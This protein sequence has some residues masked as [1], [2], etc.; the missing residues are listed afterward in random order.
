MTSAH[1]CGELKERPRPPWGRS[2]LH[3]SFDLLFFGPCLANSE[4]SRAGTVGRYPGSQH[5]AQQLDVVN[6][7]IRDD[8]DEDWSTTL[9]K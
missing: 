8:C 2:L 3:H 9:S 4:P 5:W 1:P 7:C 6:G